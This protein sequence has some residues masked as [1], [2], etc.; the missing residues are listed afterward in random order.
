MVEIIK[1]TFFKNI[2]NL[3][4]IVGIILSIWLVIIIVENP[5]KLWLIFVFSAFIGLTDFLDGKA[6]RYF[7]CKSVFGGSLDR[8]RDKIFVC[9][10]LIVLAFCYN[11]ENYGQYFALAF[12]TQLLVIAEATM[13]LFQL[14]LMFASLAKKVSIYANQNGRIKMFIQFFVLIFWMIPLSFDE[15]GGTRVMQY[16]IYPI[17]ALIIV[18]LYYLS[19]SIHC[20]CQRYADAKRIINQ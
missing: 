14:C 13:E 5:K 18:T 8:V 10:V 16:C 7:N 12:A 6:A 1:K 4:T 9:S 11:D 15:Y 19:K 17:N 2:A 3:I 20:Y